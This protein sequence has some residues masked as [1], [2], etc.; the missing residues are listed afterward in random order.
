[1]K[2]AQIAGAITPTVP[3]LIALTDWPKHHEWPPIGGLRH[4]VF[5]AKQKGFETAFV[6]CGRRVLINE[7]EFFRCISQQGGR[8]G[9]AA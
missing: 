3:K 2:S 7:S 9:A 5:H 1:M 4:L 6:R 8:H